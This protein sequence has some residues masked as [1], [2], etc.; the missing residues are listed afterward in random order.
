LIALNA[1][2]YKKKPFKNFP[3][4][5]TGFAEDA[6]AHFWKNIAAPQVFEIAAHPLSSSQP[7]RSAEATEADTRKTPPIETMP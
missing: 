3:F 2:L 7:R 6:I 1:F 5:V 4:L